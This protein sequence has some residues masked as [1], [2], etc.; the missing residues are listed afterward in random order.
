MK[1]IWFCIAAFLAVAQ[2]QAKPTSLCA[3][4][5]LPSEAIV[6]SDGWT[7]SYVV[8]IG[9]GAKRAEEALNL[10][11]SYDA[12]DLLGGE[13]IAEF[14]LLGKPNVFGTQSAGNINKGAGV[15]C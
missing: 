11:S 6:A 13:N 1:K 14:A 5:N 3:V 8:L 4:P 10:F 9:L 2:A 12:G 15:W 7:Q